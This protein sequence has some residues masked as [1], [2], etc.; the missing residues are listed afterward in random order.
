MT[1]RSAVLGAALLALAAPAAASPEQFSEG[2]IITGGY[3][4]VAKID[5]DLPLPAGMDY[6]VAF[7]VKTNKPGERSTGIDGAARFINMLAANGVPMSKIHPAIVLH[8]G[9]MFDVVNDARYGQEYGGGTNPTAALV[10]QLIAKGVPIYV[11]GQ[12]AAW[13][14]VS[15]ADLLPG[16]KMAL[17]AMTAHAVLQQQGYSLNPF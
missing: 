17:S 3:G 6:K 9:A 2:P 1:I 8:H 7:D 4:A 14:N 5:S 13:S 15:K 12:S 11:C 16:V 10:R